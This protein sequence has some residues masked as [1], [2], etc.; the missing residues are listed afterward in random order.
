VSL[1]EQLALFLAF[2]WLLKRIVRTEFFFDHMRIIRLYVFQEKK[3]E[4]TCF[5]NQLFAF[6]DEPN[7]ADVDFPCFS[8]FL[9]C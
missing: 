7:A 1:Q 8:Q 2:R 6:D 9:F 3:D 4:K 5:A